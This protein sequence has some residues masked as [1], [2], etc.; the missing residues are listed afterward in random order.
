MIPEGEDHPVPR[1]A[2]LRAL[3]IRFEGLLREG[4]IRD[5]A[6]LARLGGVSRSAAIGPTSQV[7]AG[8]RFKVE[9]QG[10]LYK[11]AHFAALIA[12]SLAFVVACYGVRMGVPIV[13]LI[14]GYR[15]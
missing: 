15:G 10:V 12:L 4:T 6:D 11:T 5:Y 9:N 3:A 8:Q 7:P 14:A 2:G 13:F 1:V